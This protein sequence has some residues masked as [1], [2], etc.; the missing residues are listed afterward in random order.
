MASAWYSGSTD[1]V[2]TSAC[3][4][5]LR[6]ITYPVQMHGSNWLFGNCGNCDF[7]GLS[8]FVKEQA[9]LGSD[10]SFKFE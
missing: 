1:F 6:M 10:L 5:S 3:E 4:P 7:S 8:S 2:T 9:G